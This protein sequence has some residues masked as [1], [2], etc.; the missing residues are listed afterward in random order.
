MPFLYGNGKYNIKG[1][2]TMPH[3]SVKMVAGRT[4]EQ[5][6]AL[7]KA[8]EKTI[9]ETLGCENM[10]VSIS[11]DDYSTVEWQDVFKTEIKDNKSLFKKP[12]YDPKIL[13]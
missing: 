8:L 10:W 12:E 5:K 13:L 2:M 4:E 7:A 11:I 1:E 6:K 9:T 3:I